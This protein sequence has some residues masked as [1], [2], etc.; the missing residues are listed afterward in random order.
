MLDLDSKYPLIQAVNIIKTTLR[1]QAS[2]LKRISKKHRLS[3]HSL[4]KERR[5]NLKSQGGTSPSEADTIAS[6]VRTAN[7]FQKQGEI[8]LN[9]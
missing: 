6:S 8:P 9:R 2:L 7:L 3:K 1:S 4:Q 5:H